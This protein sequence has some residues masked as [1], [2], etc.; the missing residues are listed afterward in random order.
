MKHMSSTES[1]FYFLEEDEAQCYLAQLIIGAFLVCLSPVNRMRDNK[2]K[3]I[4]FDYLPIPD[5][6][7]N[8]PEFPEVMD[9]IAKNLWDT[10]DKISILWSGGI[11]STAAATA[12]I[13]NCDD[14][15]QRLR[16]LYTDTS[17]LEYEQFYSNF[18]S[19]AE[20]SR[21][22]SEK[23]LF[24]RE[25]PAAL[26]D[27]L[28]TSGEC[29]DQIFGSMILA[30]DPESM[31][32]SYKEIIDWDNLITNNTDVTNLGGPQHRFL[33]EKSGSILKDYMFNYLEEQ[34]KLCPFECTTVFDFF[35]WLNYSMKWNLCVYRALTKCVLPQ[36]F[37]IDNWYPF[38]NA[39]ELHQWSIDYHD[40]KV[41]IGGDWKTYKQPAK[42]YIYE[43]DGDKE[44]LKEKIKTASL[45]LQTR[46]Y[47]GHVSMIDA[48]G[49]CSPFI[50][51]PYLEVQLDGMLTRDNLDW[52]STPRQYDMR[53]ENFKYF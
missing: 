33:F 23:D 42:D 21:E 51:M 48:N 37:N 2:F 45:S 39:P 35:W 6:T 50:W 16:F 22:V 43:L 46:T 15:K 11:D 1:M 44:Y 41:A 17:I 4:S 36:P 5:Y 19:K 10:N 7:G 9:T 14:W 18:V 24:E 12:L 20:D 40:K 30:K 31:T 26:L 49:Y 8:S 13:R 34:I 53:W 29:G 28:V 47:S 25:V 3:N 32:R 38:Y 27:S 52:S